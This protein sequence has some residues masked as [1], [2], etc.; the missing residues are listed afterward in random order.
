MSPMVSAFLLRL[1]IILWIHPCK[2]WT[3]FYNFSFN[4]TAVVHYDCIQLSSRS[5]VRLCKNYV[6]PATFYFS[7]V[8]ESKSV[9]SL[10]FPGVVLVLFKSFTTGSGYTQNC[11]FVSILYG[12]VVI[13]VVIFVLRYSYSLSIFSRITFTHIHIFTFKHLSIWEKD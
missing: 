6:T 1:W 3:I 5:C 9:V 13:L 12:F 2:I 10:L 11:K 4:W 8:K 7:S